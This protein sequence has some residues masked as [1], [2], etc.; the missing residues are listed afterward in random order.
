[1]STNEPRDRLLSIGEFS[2]RSRL[3]MKALRMYDRRGLLAPADIDPSNGYR[4][5]RE[6]QLET[7]RLIGMLRRLDIPLSLVAWVVSA[8]APDA[9]E[10][11]DLWWK[12]VERRVAAQRELV[13]YLQIQLLGEER[14][15]DMFEIHERD[16][17]EQLL[18]SEQRHTTV[19]GLSNWIG[20]T[21][22]KH[23]QTAGPLGG[24]VGPTLAIYHGEVNE[25]SDG[26]VEVCAPIKP[27]TK[28]PDGMT[29][30][31]EPAHREAYTRIRKAQVEFP[32][33][34][35]AYDAVEQ[36]IKTNGKTMT[37]SPREV[38]FTDFM[39]AGPD[40]EVCDIAFPIEAIPVGK[41]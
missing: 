22:G 26:P 40:D 8:P 7:A 12:A 29:T 2:R 1:M 13:A 9:R 23:F 32:Q 5:Y 21:F 24:V 17:P 37:G 30:R 14:S 20:E 6:S 19:D 27:D 16:I 25:D 34:L 18:L 38:Y 41:T 15:Y 33:I 10:I 36:W 4:R 39:A 3:S 11:I 31:I 35:S 28:V